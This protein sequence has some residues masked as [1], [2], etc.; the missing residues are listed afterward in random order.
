MRDDTRKRLNQA[1]WRERL[2]KAG[3][4]LAIVAAIGAIMVYQTYDLTE[5][6]TQVG[7]TIA[8]F[9]PLITKSISAATEGVKAE[10][11]L[12]SGQTVSIMALKSRGLKIGDHIDITAH[13]H[14]SGRVTYSLK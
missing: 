6:K 14:G 10:V 3:I 13:H 2:K 12:D 1:I 9:D 4:G 7:G 8:A 11:R 5:T